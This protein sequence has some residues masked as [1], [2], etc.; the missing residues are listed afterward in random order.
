MDRKRVLIICYYWP[1][2]G[3]PGVQRWLKFVKYFREFGVEPVVFVP[4]NA[5]YPL[6]DEGFSAEV[7]ND[8]EII[9]FPIK[10]PYKFAKWFSKKKTRAMSSGVFSEKKPILLEKIMLYIRGNWFIPDARVGWVP[11]SVK[12]LTK[13]LEDQGISTVITTGPPHS[14]HLIGLQLKKKLGIQWISDFRDPWTTIHYHKSLRLTKASEKRHKQLE[15]EVLTTADHVVV[16]SPHTKKEFSEITKKPITVITNGYDASEEIVPKL[17]TKFSL[18]HVGSLMSQRNPVVLWEVVRDLCAENEAF[19]NSF[20][21][22]LIGTVSMEIQ[23]SLL[24]YELTSYTRMDGYVSHTEALQA[25]HDAQLLLLIEMDL[26]ETRAIIPG[27]LFEYLRA[28]RP[29]VAI[30]PEGSDI[31]TILDETHSGHFFSYSEK[32]ALKSHLLGCFEAYQRGELV[33]HSEN[34]E[35]YSRRELTKSMT[36]LLKEV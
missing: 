18:V 16:T 15:R 12:F 26:P 32:E 20:E 9:K 27:K 33:S 2:A 1:P 31:K 6:L 30:G 8:I 21:L 19:K 11:P 22:K 17:D 35:K 3:G 13:Y 24:E 28:R 23:K 7:P 34:I 25:Q 10:E 36:E 14:L 29:I 4:E 5:H